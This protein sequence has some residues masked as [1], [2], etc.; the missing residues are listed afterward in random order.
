MKSDNLFI[1]FKG[2]LKNE[3]VSF[4]ER[5]GQNPSVSFK[6]HSESSL[7]FVTVHFI[8]SKNTLLCRTDFPLRIPNT[9]RIKILD[10]LSVINSESLISNFILDP[11]NYLWAKSSLYSCEN[12]IEDETFRRFLFVN[13][14]SLQYQF[15]RIM[16][17][18]EIYSSES[19]TNPD[20]ISL[21]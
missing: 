16:I 8:E 19:R 5:F 15:K 20:R 18:S 4:I 6:F 9:K 10:F 21:N 11:N 2:F 12:T 17:L 3:G 7:L 13:I 14:S 1:Q